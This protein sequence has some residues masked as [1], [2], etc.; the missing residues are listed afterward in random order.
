M[1]SL[2]HPNI[3]RY[4]DSWFDEWAF[5][6]NLNSVALP[7]IGES[8]AS[9]DTPRLYRELTSSSSTSQSNHPDASSSST[10]NITYLYI[11][12]ELCQTGTLKDWLDKHSGQRPVEKC[13]KIFKS[14]VKAVDYV[15]QL[16]FMHRDIKVSQLLTLKKNL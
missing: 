4:Y 3:V 9:I 11:R 14:V 2:N 8:K 15:H 16:N 7:A 6:C 1:A 5:D 12:M 13:V 10:D